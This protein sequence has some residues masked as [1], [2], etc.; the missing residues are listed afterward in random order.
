[1]I[2]IITKLLLIGLLLGSALS[3][4]SMELQGLANPAN[5]ELIGAVKKSNLA[6]VE[7]ALK[8]GANI[9]YADEL[10]WTALTYAAR[11]DT[12]I[13]RILID[14]GADVNCADVHGNS[15]LMWATN[16]GHIDIVRLLLEQGADVNHADNNG[17]TALIWAARHGH[18]DI[19]RMLIGH[20]ADINHTDN[21]GDTA[22]M[23]QLNI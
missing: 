11:R 9:N 12:D 4:E 7:A 20:G 23:W 17:N 10:D 6:A 2:K 16:A 22:L 19:A 8:A 3:L 13:V 21:N 14:A 1:M 18:E 15:A 5:E